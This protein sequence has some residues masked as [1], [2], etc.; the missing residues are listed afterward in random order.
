MSTSH[1]CP[2]AGVVSG[3]CRRG[4]RR[5]AAAFAVV[6]VIG[7]GVGGPALTEVQAQTGVQLNLDEPLVVRSELHTFRVVTVAEG[8]DQPWSIAFLP[9]GDV[10]VTEKPGR[11]RVIRN[12]TLLPD[13]IPGTPEVRAEGQGGLLEVLPHPDFANN[14]LLY[15]TY[16]KPS[17][18]GQRST[19][20]VARARF[21]GTQL[22]ELEDIFVAEAWSEGG[23]HYGSRL[24]FHPDGHLF[25]TVGDRA[26]NPLGGPR[27][28]HPAQRLDTHQGKV[29]RLQDDGSVPRDNPFVNQEGALPEI[30]SYGHR[31]LQG[32]VIDQQG[33]VW[34][35]EHGAQGGDE[36]NLVQPGRNYGWPVITYGV[37]YGG[38]RIHEA[39][40]REGMEQPIQFWTP[41]IAPSGLMQYTGD[42]FP[43]WRGDFFVGGLDGRQIAR[44]ELTESESGIQVERL[45]RPALLWGI[46]RVRDIRQA[47]DGTIYVALD[48]RRDNSLTR[49]VRLEPVE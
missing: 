18:D 14:R 28:E 25:V 11:L 44:L 48:G 23:A 19:T 37:Q 10:L 41:S 4:S 43:E 9:E 2:M 38:I 13:P 6:T 8:L 29:L 26:A 12:G 35:T 5:I 17:P 33:R 1:T 15:F 40:E 27:E 34:T 3:W 31:N 42:R 39:R 16:S 36:L 21:D 30:W 20:A 22:S 46:G 32:L 7:G 49:V 47:P 24:A 45:E